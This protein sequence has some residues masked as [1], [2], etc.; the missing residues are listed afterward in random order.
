M[1]LH[2]IVPGGCDDS[3]GIQVAQLAGVPEEV[4][5][6]AREILELL[7]SGQ[8][9]TQKIRRLGG[10]K[11]RVERYQGY[12]ISLFDPE[13]HPL[14]VALRELDIN[15]LTPLEALNILAEWKKKWNR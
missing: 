4:I 13:Y 5:E 3:Y 9:P 2:K 8:M 10:R 14:V 11:G 1:F 12:Q 7:E 15:K 6:R